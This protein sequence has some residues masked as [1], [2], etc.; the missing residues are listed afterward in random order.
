MNFE[1]PTPSLTNITRNVG[2][3]YARG[4][5]NADKTAL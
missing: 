1:H 4:I 5:K 3:Y 2:K